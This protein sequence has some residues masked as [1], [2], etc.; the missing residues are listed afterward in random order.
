MEQGLIDLLNNFGAGT[1]I[2]GMLCIVSGVILIIKKLIS[3]KKKYDENH[4]SKI[5]QD[6]QQK[7]ESENV[8]KMIGKFSE[9]ETKIDNQGK[10]LK[11]YVDER[12]DI[13]ETRLNANDKVISDLNKSVLNT[14]NSLSQISES[15]IKINGS[16]DILI[17]SDCETIRSFI[18]SEYCKWVGEDRGEIDLI[19]LQ[20]IE[21]MYK[22]FLEEVGENTDEFI[23]KLVQEIRQLPT[24]R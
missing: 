6:E 15:L 16:I 24:K 11:S 9:L 12:Y 13:L 7:Q 19:S 1:F 21:R 3:I 22:K 4:T 10:E 20:N 17:D 2:A 8:E 23:D 5:L 14:N 18:M